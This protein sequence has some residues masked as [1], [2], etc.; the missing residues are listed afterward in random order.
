MITLTGRGRL[1][2]TSYIAFPGPIDAKGWLAG[3]N[4]FLGFIRA[5]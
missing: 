4:C 5:L 2:V 3:I 1:R